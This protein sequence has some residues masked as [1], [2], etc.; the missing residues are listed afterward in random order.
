MSIFSHKHDH[1]AIAVQKRA[2]APYGLPGTVILR[3]CRC[4]GVE[5]Q[6]ITG[7]WTLAQVRGQR[8]LTATERVEL[9][10]AVRA[11]TEAKA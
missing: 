7:T 9:D 2:Q 11:A 8:D 10:L 1:E 4:G 3:R 5:T 6:E